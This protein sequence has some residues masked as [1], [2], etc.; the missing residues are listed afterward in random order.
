MNYDVV[1]FGVINAKDLLALIKMQTLGNG[2]LF[3]F[4]LNW[5]TMTT[6]RIV[7]PAP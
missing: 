3:G 1:D 2:N 4:A 5:K 7:V 6:K